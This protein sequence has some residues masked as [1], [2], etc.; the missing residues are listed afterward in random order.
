MVRGW[1]VMRVQ[2]SYSTHLVDKTQAKANVEHIA[3]MLAYCSSMRLRSPAS[4][5]HAKSP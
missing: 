3:T 5:P 1:R 4:V 2:A